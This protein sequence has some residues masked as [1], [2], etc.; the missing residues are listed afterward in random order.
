MGRR[1]AGESHFTFL[2]LLFSSVTMLRRPPNIALPSGGRA[3]LE[4]NFA[5]EDVRAA[6]EA[7]EKAKQLGTFR[8]MRASSA[9]QRSRT[10]GHEWWARE[11]ALIEH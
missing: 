10:S 3:D 5:M 6:Q 1:G 9:C 4:R 11:E 7:A 2:F 8:A